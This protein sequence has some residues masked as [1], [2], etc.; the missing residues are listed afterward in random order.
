MV[1][2]QRLPSPDKGELNVR[3]GV[4]HDMRA[5][6]V[7]FGK[8]VDWIGMGVAEARQLGDMLHGFADE[9]ERKR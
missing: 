9:L 6:I 8:A 3:I 7:D 5:V 2:G 1:S 4:N